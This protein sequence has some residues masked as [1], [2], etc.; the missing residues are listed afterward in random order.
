MS[1]ANLAERRKPWEERNVFVALGLALLIPGLGHLYQGRTVKGL[2]YLFGILG[3]FL[4]GVKLGEG[5][6]VYNTPDKGLA[7][8]VTLHY[9]AQFGAGAIS[10]PVLWQKQRAMSDSNRPVRQVEQPLTAHFTGSLIA[11]DRDSPLGK[12][13]GTVAL[14]PEQGEYG[15]ET[16]GVFTGTLDG[17]PV[18]LP[19]AG[20]FDLDRPIAAGFRRG[21]RCGVAGESESIPGAGKIIVGS[22]P[23]SIFDGYG[24]PPDPE[25]LQELT[26]RLGKLHELALVFT[27]IAGL[28]NILAIWD[29]VQGPAYGFGDEAWLV[30]ASDVPADPAIPPVSAPLSNTATP[31]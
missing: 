5:V 22:I 23:R 11:T 16:R 31:A 7:R 28:L 20:N 25:Q 12:L 8:R 14:K 30:P 4:W 21:L 24:V 13:D 26:G 3:L 10:F 9:A 2:I 6:V 29:C 17:Q 18:E 19:L 15:L 1:T 27:W